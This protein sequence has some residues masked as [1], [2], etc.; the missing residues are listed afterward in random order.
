M[1]KSSGI[2]QIEKF[3][4]AARELQTNDDERDFDDRLA[5]IARHKPVKNV[6]SPADKGRK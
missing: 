6:D 1:P 3:K 4:Q 2:K 5:E